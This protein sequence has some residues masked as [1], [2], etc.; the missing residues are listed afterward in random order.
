MSRAAASRS[1]VDRLGEVCAFS[2]FESM[3]LEMPDRSASCPTLRPISRRRLR[4][5][6]AMTQESWLAGPP[7]SAAP[8][9]PWSPPL[10]AR[11]AGAFAVRRS[12]M[13]ANIFDGPAPASPEGEFIGT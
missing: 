9:W 6:F 5:W 8:P 3:P 4:T 12:D 13:P 2:I 11:R 1:M 7:G 10:T